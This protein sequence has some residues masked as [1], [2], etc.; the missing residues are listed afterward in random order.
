[1][2][3]ARFSLLCCWVSSAFLDVVLPWPSLATSDVPAY[4]ETSRIRFSLSVLWDWW[5]M[6]LGLCSCTAGGKLVAGALR[7]IKDAIR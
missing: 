6:A 1:M 2:R 4:R 7:E 5:D 3:G